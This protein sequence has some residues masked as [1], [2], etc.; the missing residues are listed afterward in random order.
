MNIQPP[1]FEPHPKPRRKYCYQNAWEFVMS[2]HGWVLVHGVA[3]G[4]GPDSQG[5]AMGHAW[6]EKAT[7]YRFGKR[8]MRQWWCLDV[9]T[10]MLIAREVFYVIGKIERTVRYRREQAFSWAEQTMVYGPWS[11]AI[12]SAAHSGNVRSFKR[13]RKQ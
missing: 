12:S 1:K 11:K 5:V 10:G 13:K 8:Q 2:N 3:R 9:L 6:V 4:T 7:R